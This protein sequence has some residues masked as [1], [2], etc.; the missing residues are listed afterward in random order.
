MGPNRAKRGRAVP[1]GAKR[2]QTGKAWTDGTK[3]G[4]SG[5]NRAN[6]G[7]KGIIRGKPGP[8]SQTKPNL[9]NSGGKT[10]SILPNRVKRG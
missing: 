1:N 10:G 4:Q 6:L 7:Q 8:T 9:V 3:R 5:P 2:D